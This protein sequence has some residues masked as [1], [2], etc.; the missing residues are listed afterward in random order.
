MNENTCRRLFS[1]IPTVVINAKQL[2][3]DPLPPPSKVSEYSPEFFQGTEDPFSFRR[4]GRRET[5]R[6]LERLV[7]DP[8]FRRQLQVWFFSTF[9]C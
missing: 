1:F 8:V 2:A 5:E 9:C 4:R 6:L 3:C 7:P